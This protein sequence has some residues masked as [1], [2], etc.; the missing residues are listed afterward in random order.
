MAL[1][2]K[3]ADIHEDIHHSI[4]LR[5]SVY[6][7]SCS[8][9]YFCCTR[10]HLTYSPQWY[11]TSP[12][13]TM[14]NKGLTASVLQGIIGEVN[15]ESQSH[16]QKVWSP[17]SLWLKAILSLIFLGELGSFIWLAVK[18]D[19]WDV[20][21]Y[22][23]PSITIFVWLFYLISVNRRIKKAF[24]LTSQ[25]MMHYV[26][27]EI[28]EKWESSNRIK[29]SMTRST[30]QE[31]QA[32]VTYDIRIT[33]LPPVTTSS[34]IAGDGYGDHQQKTETSQYVAPVLHQDGGSEGVSV[35]IM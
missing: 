9:G 5:P 34:S 30:R 21:P 20:I 17:M 25:H 8:I 4:I 18:I 15:E 16:F 12:T 10:P 11:P 29:W 33:S 31:V 26:S 1:I 27:V 14:K 28:N 35:T 32:Y 19:T 6:R 23:M 13:G 3:P 2:V 24:K 22:C 7:F